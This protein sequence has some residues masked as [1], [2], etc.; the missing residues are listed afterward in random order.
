MDLDDEPGRVVRDR[1]SVPPP[2]GSWTQK[3]N[4]LISLRKESRNRSVSLPLIPTLGLDLVGADEAS[5]ESGGAASH[6]AFAP[7]FAGKY[8]PQHR[9]VGVKGLTQLDST[10]D[11]DSSGRVAGAS[12]PGVVAVDATTDESESQSRLNTDRAVTRSR[13]HTEAEDSGESSV[14][15]E[16]RSRAGSAVSETD[17]PRSEEFCAKAETEDRY[18]FAKGFGQ[19]VGLKRLYT[20]R[21]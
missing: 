10:D 9:P 17:S 6:H 3:L 19:P 11:S 8:T 20:K 1:R 2:V 13:S 15:V 18:A 7:G 16:T 21:N 12:A 14:R 5:S 4:K